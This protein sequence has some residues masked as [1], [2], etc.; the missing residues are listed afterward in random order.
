MESAPAKMKRLTP[1]EKSALALA[2]LF[3]IAGAG[4]IIFPQDSFIIHPGYDNFGLG[5]WN[6]EE[7]VSRRRSQVY[8]GLAVLAGVGIACLILMRKKD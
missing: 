7:H 6:W 4:M 1:L 2:M 8:G 5:R 3:F